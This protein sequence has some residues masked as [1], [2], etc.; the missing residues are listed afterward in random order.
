MTLTSI[1]V[2]IKLIPYFAG[3]S[4]MPS[5]TFNPE[6]LMEI[7]EMEVDIPGTLQFYFVNLN[8]AFDVA[9]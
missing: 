8:V 1:S 9:Q 5:Y 3:S 4:G 2:L 7:E 6:E